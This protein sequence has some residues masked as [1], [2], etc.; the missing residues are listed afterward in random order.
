MPIF[1]IIVY[2]KS[3]LLYKLCLV[4]ISRFFLIFSS[5]FLQKTNREL[6]NLEH[7]MPKLVPEWRFE[8]NMFPLS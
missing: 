7:A 3:D 8:I 5:I 1:C 6:P 2:V 4:V